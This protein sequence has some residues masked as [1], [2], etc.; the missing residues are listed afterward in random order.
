M[1]LP[2]GDIV[3]ALENCEDELSLWAA[4]VI[5]SLRDEIRLLRIAQDNRLRVRIK[6]PRKKKERCEH[7]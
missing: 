7:D 4:T 1:S 6:K 5:T 3:D 2:T